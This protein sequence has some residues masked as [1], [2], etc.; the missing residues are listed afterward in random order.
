MYFVLDLDQ[1]VVFEGTPE[2]VEDWLLENTTKSNEGFRV[3]MGES[4][5]IISALTY[6]GA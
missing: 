1:F 5:P 6:I 3:L 4:G 2:E